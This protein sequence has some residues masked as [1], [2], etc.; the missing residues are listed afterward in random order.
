MARYAPKYFAEA[1][2]G[3]LGYQWSIWFILSVCICRNLSPERENAFWVFI[4]EV[5][6][7]RSISVFFDPIIKGIQG[8]TTFGLILFTYMIF[9]GFSFSSFKLLG[10]IQN[11]KLKILIVILKLSLFMFGI[12][13]YSKEPTQTVA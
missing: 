3:Q 13:M 10:V 5:V 1:N 7:A 8:T 2:Y 4:M 12:L 11:F 6:A 9:L